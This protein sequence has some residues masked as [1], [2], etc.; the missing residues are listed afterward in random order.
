MAILVEINASK[1]VTWK[2]TSGVVW[3]STETVVWQ[4]SETGS[5]LYLSLDGEA[6]AHYWDAYIA[7]FAAPQY[8]TREKHGGYVE[9]SF[10]QINISPDAFSGTWPP[11]K[12]LDVVIHYT[13]TTEIDKVT[14]FSGDIHLISFDA[15]SVSYNIYAPKYTQR[16]L[17]EGPNYDGDTVPYPRA[18]GTITHQQPLRLADDG[19]SQPCYHLAGISTTAAAFEVISF[20]YYAAGKT[21]VTLSAAHGWSDSDSII[22]ESSTNFS[23][24]HTIESASGASFVIP[25]AFP[26]DNSELLPIIA[27]AKEAGSFCV[28]DDG[29]PIQSN[30]VVNGDGTF[31]LTASP[32]GIVTMSGTASYTDLEGVMTWGQSRLEG[33]GSV[34]T[35]YQRATSPG[36][37]VWANSQQPVIDFLS[38]IAAFFT[39]YFYIKDTVLY[40]GDMLLDAGSDT[41]DEY[42]Y[43][44]ASYQ[45]HSAIR[46]ISAVWD[47]YSAAEGAVN[48]DSVNMAR[49]IK[50]T[51]NVVIES[52]YTIASGTADGTQAHHLVDSAATFLS[53]GVSVGDTVQNTTDNTSTFVTAVSD[54]LLQ[55]NDNIFVSG[56]D[57]VVGPSFP[58]G[59]DMSLTPF[60]NTKSNVSTALQNILSILNS[61]VGEIRIPISATL[62]APGTKLTWS[63]TLLVVSTTTWIRARGMTYDFENEE[64]VISGEGV[65][66]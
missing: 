31:S 3:K 47:T 52:L 13:A 51:K 12:K 53:D 15:E 28:Y 25:V 10:G 16:L 58:Y 64:V 21:T 4:D 46:Q 17:D 43:L 11:P 41:L 35:T 20:T 62:P 55:L 7:S 49:Y 29:V 39:H 14:I 19:S 40:L 59:T 27:T 44:D 54:T 65:I 60:H 30:V 24:T 57:Y 22:I 48:N 32:V 66:A 23:G 34:D 45:A 5:T 38:E 8:Q 56:E 63:D 18:F 26:T 9:L 6:L 61:D 2:D 33:V 42:E 50:T 37:S 36:V 1:E